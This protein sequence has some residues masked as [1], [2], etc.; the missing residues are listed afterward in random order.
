MDR[1]N[2]VTTTRAGRTRTS[3]RRLEKSDNG[4]SEMPT[5]VKDRAADTSSSDA[6][7]GDT[8]PLARI[9]VSLNLLQRDIDIIDALAEER[10]VTKTEVIRAAIATEKYLRDAAAQGEKILV[11]DGE[12]RLRQLVF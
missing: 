4:G 11:E 7:V 12:G 10:G 6:T 8:S 5:L 2:L 9:K 1:G 3:R